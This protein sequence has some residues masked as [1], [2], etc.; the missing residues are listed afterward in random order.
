MGGKV[1]G[2]GEESVNLGWGIKGWGKECEFRV[3]VKG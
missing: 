1:K 2:W 3:G